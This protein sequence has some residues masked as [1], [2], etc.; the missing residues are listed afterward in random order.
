MLPLKYFLILI[1]LI[2]LV[3]Y[4][5]LSQS[6]L[7]IDVTAGYSNPLLELRGE[8]VTINSTQD[9]I[10]LNGKRILIS[11]NLGTAAGY[12]VQTYLKYS[13][14][15]GYF[16][17]IF[18]L[19]YNR[20][21][22][23]HDAPDGSTFG[24]KFQSFSIG[25]GGEFQALPT[26]RFSPSLFGLLRVNFLG[27]E[28]F[29]Y[30]GFDFFKVVPRYGYSAGINLNYLVSKKIGLT[31]GGSYSY[32]NV[33]SKDTDETVTSDVHTIVFRD[34][35]NATNGL[36]ADRRVAYAS[37]YFGMNFILK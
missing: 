23:H 12:N 5:I 4:P 11:D 24:V 18:N 15:K 22:S 26:K 21:F 3:N 37:F 19:G 35:A 2:I 20:T 17:G 32:D 10:Y 8:N 33:W 7:E 25:F 31:F 27:G 30:A 13:M 16:K 28:T 14:F 6:K 29:N 34:K 36:S 9:L 1:G